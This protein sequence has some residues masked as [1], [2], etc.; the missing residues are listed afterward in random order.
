[1]LHAVAP[2]LVFTFELGAVFA[3]W[4][5][6]APICFKRGADYESHRDADE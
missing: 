1:M 6:S 3:L 2:A 4:N 5:E